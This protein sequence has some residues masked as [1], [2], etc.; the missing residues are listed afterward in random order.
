ME[1]EKSP[2]AKPSKPK[3]KSVVPIPLPDD[4]LGDSLGGPNPGI[5]DIGKTEKETEKD[6]E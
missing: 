5:V 4:T 3:P 1:Q 6:T 2:D